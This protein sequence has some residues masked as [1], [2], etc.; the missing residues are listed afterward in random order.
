M[1]KNKKREEEI[2]DF[3]KSL[4]LIDAKEFDGHTNFKELSALEKL[5]WLSVLNDFKHMAK[6]RAG[7]G[8]SE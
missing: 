2:N 1:K 4:E 7:P 6:Q 8:E 3:R 5:I